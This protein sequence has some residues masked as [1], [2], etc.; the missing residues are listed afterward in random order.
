MAG[1]TSEREAAAFDR[2]R[3]L[4]LLAARMAAGD[5]DALVGLYDLTLGRVYGLAL[6]IVGEAAAAEDVAEE[7]YL[8]VWRQAAD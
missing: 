7:V 6:R 1:Q 4:S 8:P 2:D 3:E 5:E